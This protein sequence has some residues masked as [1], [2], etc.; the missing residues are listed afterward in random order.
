[1]QLADAREE[2]R[3]QAKSGNVSHET[4][5]R[6][7]REEI[8]ADGDEANQVP[9]DMEDARLCELSY[10]REASTQSMQRSLDGLQCEDHE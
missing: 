5:L 4:L 8:G 10:S 3:G 2:Q 7:F 6:V 9:A 1:M